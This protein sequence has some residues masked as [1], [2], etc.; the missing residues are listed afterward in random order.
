MLRPSETF[1]LFFPRA[2]ADAAWQALTGNCYNFPEIPTAAAASPRAL[3]IHLGVLRTETQAAK[4]DAGRLRELCFAVLLE[5]AEIARMRREQVARIPA[6]RRATREELLRRLL[7]AEDYLAGTGAKATVAGAADAA[8]LSPF[9]L[10]R[11][12]K[13]AFGKTPLAY[14]VGARL[15]RAH[16]ELIKTGKPIAEIAET[17]GYESRTAFDRAFA[18]R[19]GATPGAVR[20]AR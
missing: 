7:R 14:A 9:H 20:A 5:I 18:R 3:Q 8:A 16:D 6:A 13:A 11:V 15:E 1:A 2:A 19:Y 17:A 12:F 10:I 4:P